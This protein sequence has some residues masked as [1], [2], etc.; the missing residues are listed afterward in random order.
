LALW[1]RLGGITDL[2]SRL[3]FFDIAVNDYLVFLAAFGACAL[4]A[5]GAQEL[6]DGRGV[7]AF[8]ICGLAS[9]AVFVSLNQ[10]LRPHFVEMVAKP[11]RLALQLPAPG[12]GRPLAG[13]LPALSSGK[14]S[15]NRTG[16]TGSFRRRWRRSHWPGFSS[17]FAGA[18]EGRPSPPAS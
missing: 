5:L 9:I 17:R 13:I 11:H 6:I 1:A 4:A 14:W 7:A 18:S 16:S 15:R 3:P 2:V 8:V 12:P 10:S